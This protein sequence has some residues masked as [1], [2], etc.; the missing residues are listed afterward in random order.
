MS[1]GKI[2][3]ARAIRQVLSDY[4]SEYAKYPWLTFAGIILPGI[5][6]IFVFFVPPLIVSQILNTISIHG[7]IP[8][9]DAFVS[10]VLFGVLWFL[11]EACWRVGMYYLTKLETLSMVNLSH[12]SFG[13]LME[14]DY[15]FYADHFV[16]SLTKKAHAYARNFEGFTDTI[17]LNVTPNLLPMIFALIVL[18]RYSLW[19]SALLLGALLIVIAI[20]IPLIK[21]RARLVAL[22]HDAASALNGRLSDILSNVLAVKAFATEDREHESFDMHATT[23]AK[24]FRAAADFHTFHIDTVLSPLYVITNTIG[25]IAAIYFTELYHLPPGALV[26]VFSYYGTVTRSFW[27]INN[28]YR[29]IENS[30]GEAA[31]FSEFV[32]PKP[33]VQDI[34]G[35]NP[36]IPKDGSIVFDRVNFDYI[37]SAMN[38]PFL[39]NFSLNILPGQRVGLVG[40]SGGGKTT[41]TKLIMRFLNIQ[42]G[43]IM[44][45]GQ[46]RICS[47]RTTSLSSQFV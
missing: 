11:G 13:Q 35:A 6:S 31:E 44:I 40:P 15:S 25:L 19:I 5:G 39:N 8:F 38:E 21:K 33:I 36:L 14:R 32:I 28:V 22:R 41:I 45:D 10:V 23:Y 26:V 27:Q 7:T 16:G 9:S 34:S 17:S 47:A 42:S 20:T 1:K 12:K 18:A 37:E 3:N 24:A 30:I 46:N 29:N 43:V 2:Y 4:F